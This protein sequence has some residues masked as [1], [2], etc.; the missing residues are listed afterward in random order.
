MTVGPTAASSSPGTPQ[1]PSRWKT[2][3]SWVLP[4]ATLAQAHDLA[5]RRWPSGVTYG[6]L[7]AVVTDGDQL[8]ARIA[9]PRSRRTGPTLKARLVPDDRGLV[10]RGHL[11]RM[12][13]ARVATWIGI[14]TVIALI[15]AIALAVVVSAT[16]GVVLSIELALVAAFGALTP[17]FW[18]A[19]IRNQQEETDKLQAALLKRFAVDD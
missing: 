10:I 19:S 12:D 5:D 8:E 18:R 17:G 15:A 4:G 7:V 13:S 11:S 6:Q 2:E 14:W 3:V 16:S 1:G 9:Y